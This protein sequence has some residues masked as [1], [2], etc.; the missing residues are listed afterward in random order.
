MRTS[1][2]EIGENYVALISDLLTVVR[3]DSVS[4]SGGWN[5]TNRD[6]GRKIRIKSVRQLRYPAGREWQHAQGG[7]R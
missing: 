7:V 1:E 3:I 5:A 6:S 4:H 2:I